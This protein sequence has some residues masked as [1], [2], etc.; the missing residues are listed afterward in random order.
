M[1]VKRSNKLSNDGRIILSDRKEMVE[2]R[3]KQENTSKETIL[4]KLFLILHAA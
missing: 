1:T 3:G 4:Q 2:R